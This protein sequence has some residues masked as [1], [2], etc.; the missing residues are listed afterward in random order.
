V[1]YEGHCDHN[2]SHSS[3][4][5]PCLVYHSSSASVDNNISHLYHVSVPTREHNMVYVPHTENLLPT[6]GFLNLFYMYYPSP[7]AIFIH[8]LK[9][10][11]VYIPTIYMHFGKGEISSLFV[12]RI[13]TAIC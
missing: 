6:S 7:F 10:P 2:S 12:I 5:V 4:G 3:Q 11:T 8:F 13:F 9:K 1:P